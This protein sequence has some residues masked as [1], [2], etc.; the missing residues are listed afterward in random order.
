MIQNAVQYRAHVHAQKSKHRPRYPAAA[1]ISQPCTPVGSCEYA[2]E[3]CIADGY[4]YVGK[5]WMS[6]LVPAL[7]L[8][9]LYVIEGYIIRSKGR[10][11]IKA[12]AA[13]TSER[14]WKCVLL[15]V[16]VSFWGTI[17]AIQGFPYSRP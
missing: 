14:Y 11:N 8:M 12:R 16:F 4:T 1:S 6:I 9:A 13:A 7:M 17:G 15:I 10:H 5:L 3:G 2:C